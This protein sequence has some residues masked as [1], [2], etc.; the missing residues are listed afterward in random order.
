[1]FFVTLAM[2]IFGVGVI[3]D[4]AFAMNV[5]VI[6]GTYSSIF[7]ASPILIWLNDKYA[8]DPAEAAGPPAAP[9]AA[10]RRRTRR[11]LTFHIAPS[12]ACAA[13]ERVGVR[14]SR[15]RAPFAS[16][17]QGRDTKKDIH[18][19]AVL[20]SSCESTRLARAVD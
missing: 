5:G 9:P 20:A 2:N 4:F 7:I 11:R 18:K 19:A 8:R 14:A 12:P 3:R 6:V 15:F 10:R 1:M 13:W 17:P 16:Y